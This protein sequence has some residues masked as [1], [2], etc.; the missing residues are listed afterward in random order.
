M[1]T[2]LD[3]LP[4][5]PV[6]DVAQRVARHWDLS[7]MFPMP[8]WDVQCPVCRSPLVQYRRVLFFRRRRFHNPYRCDV[9]MKCRDC[10]AIWTHGVVIPE[11]MYYRH[12]KRREGCLYEW[13]AVRSLLRPETMEKAI[14]S[15]E[16]LQAEYEA[17]H[18]RMDG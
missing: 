1:A 5:E 7:G 6:E 10:S 16:A 17:A 9:D 13:K 3:L 2:G 18:R 11:E 8:K 14:L 12:C 15:L 4:V